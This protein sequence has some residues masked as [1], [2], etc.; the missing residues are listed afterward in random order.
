M[1]QG[2]A[3]DSVF[4]S[5]EFLLYSCLPEKLI[6]LKLDFLKKERYWIVKPDVCL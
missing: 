2:K 4:S 6:N 5:V 1:S 3:V